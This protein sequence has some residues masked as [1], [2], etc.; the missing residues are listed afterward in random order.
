MTEGLFP[1]VQKGEFAYLAPAFFV[2]RQS[3]RVDVEIYVCAVLPGYF[4]GC[5]L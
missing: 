1:E 4:C 3:Q 5:L 2:C